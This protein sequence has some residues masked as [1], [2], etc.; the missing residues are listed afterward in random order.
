MNT[1]ERPPYVVVTKVVHTLFVKS[2]IADFR[3][4]SFVICYRLIQTDRLQLN[5]SIN[6]IQA[7]PVNFRRVVLSISP[8]DEL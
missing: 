4:L 8:N 1:L 2:V 6:E 3:C 5:D 7:T